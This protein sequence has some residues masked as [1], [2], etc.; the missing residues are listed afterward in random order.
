MP[1]DS[2]S[3]AKYGP[4]DSKSFTEALKGLEMKAK[5]SPM[6]HVADMYLWPMG[7]AAC[8]PNQRSFVRLRDCGRLV[9]CQ[10]A[11]DARSYLGIKY[12][13]FKLTTSE[14]R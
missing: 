9:D 5:S 6:L 12:S 1:F 8:D 4:L 11:E 14:V 10:I 13:C 2:E 7:K 3:M